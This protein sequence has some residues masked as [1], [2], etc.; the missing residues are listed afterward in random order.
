MQAMIESFGFCW[1]EVR[2]NRLV[3]A[4]KY[5]SRDQA[6]GEAEAELAYLNRIKVID[7]VLSDDVDTFL[8]GGV[9]IIRKCVSTRSSTIID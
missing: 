7:M 4:Q 9:H 1:R 8:F 5:S 3:L 6:P 2:K